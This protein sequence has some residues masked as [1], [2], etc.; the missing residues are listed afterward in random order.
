MTNKLDDI[1][2]NAKRARLIPTVPDSN[3]EVKIVSILLATL[4]MVPPLSKALLGPCG[5]KVG[6][7]STL[8]SYT[9]VEFEADKGKDKNRPDGVLILQTGKNFWKAILEAKV[10]RNDIEEGQVQRYAE[11]ARQYGV[12]AIIT[13]SNQLVPL[14]SHVPYSVPRM[15]G[16]SRI[17]FFHISWTNVLTQASLILKNK[18]GLNLEQEFILEEM[19]YYFKNPKSGIMRFS[20]MNAEWKSLAQGVRDGK[21]FNTSN[22]EIKNSVASWYQEE[23]DISLILSRRIGQQIEIQ[24]SPSHKKSPE[25]R[26]ADTC[27]S[28]ITDQELRSV[29]RVPNAA[30]PIELVANLQRRTI[31]CSMRIDAPGHRSTA[32]GRIG[33]VYQQL[34]NIDDK[35]VIVRAYW[36]GRAPQTQVTLSELK[37]DP[38][39]LASERSN[40]M[41]TK[42]EVIIS[43]DL[44]GRF[45]MPQK[46]IEELENLVP[47]FYDRIGQKLRK[48]TPAAPT[49]EKSD[50]IQDAEKLKKTE[51]SVDDDSVQPEAN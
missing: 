25:D 51:E 9:E 21:Q 5:A 46:F 15:R 47:D 3:K 40:T 26:F 2:Q 45:W 48:W 36:S 49:I 17:E 44:A 10:A 37:A 20:Q 1:L 11:L 29:Y 41:P 32:Q 22:L 13:L 19:I 8:L 33:W 38:K 18:D 23:R 43:R 31:S 34:K 50:P 16:K 24:L 42:F 7:T 6:K 30:S 4:S 14:P 12:D 28:L 39:C 27:N 35:D